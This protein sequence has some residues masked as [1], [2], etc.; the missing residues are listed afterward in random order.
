MSLADGIRKVIDAGIDVV[1]IEDPALISILELVKQ[2]VNM[3]GGIEWLG[4]ELR[5][6]VQLRKP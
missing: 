3:P 5:G 2:V 6:F 1:E 4:N